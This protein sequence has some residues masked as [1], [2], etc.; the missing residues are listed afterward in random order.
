[1]KCR[2]YINITALLA[3]LT[4]WKPHAGFDRSDAE[5]V[6]QRVCPYDVALVFMRCFI[7]VLQKIFS[8]SFKELIHSRNLLEESL[9]VCMTTLM[10][11]TTS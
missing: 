9:L 4:V 2:S 7:V 6:S 5:S 11:L 10:L 1:M 3:F 8:C